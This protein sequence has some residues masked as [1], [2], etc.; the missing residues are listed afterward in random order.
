MFLQAVVPGENS[1]CPNPEEEEDVPV[2]AEVE[3]I[4][5][6]LLNGLKDPDTIVR[7]GPLQ[8]EGM[9][10]QHLLPRYSCSKC[11]TADKHSCSKALTT[12][13]YCCSKALTTNRYSCSKALTT[14]SYSCNKALTTNRY[15][16]NKALTTNRYSCSKGVGRVCARLPLMLAGEVVGAVLGCF[17]PTESHHACHG[18]C[19]AL[20]EL[21]T[22]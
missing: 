9:Y 4:I 7:L 17:S 12:N 14:K 20:A 22:L 5:D 13:R 8:G 3:D 15:S 10:L 2:A 6:E 16:C 21:G 19:L 18:G 1:S 11:F